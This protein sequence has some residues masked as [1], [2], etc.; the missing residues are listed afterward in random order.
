MELMNQL[1]NANRVWLTVALLLCF[2]A[3]LMF[4]PERIHRPVCFQAAIWLFALSLVVSNLTVMVFSHGPTA[5][6]PQAALA[7]FGQVSAEMK[8]AGLLEQLM[9]AGSVLAMTCSLLPPTPGGRP[10]ASGGTEHLSA[11]QSP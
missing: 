6:N 1:M 4:R 2:V 10:S 7:A 9:F 11:D 8:V 3:V 5:G